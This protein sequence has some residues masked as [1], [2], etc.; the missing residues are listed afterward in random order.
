MVMKLLILIILIIYYK[1]L[2]KKIDY[3]NYSVNL[4]IKGA[5]F[6]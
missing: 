3:I 6:I 5:E 1:N 4:E 2:F